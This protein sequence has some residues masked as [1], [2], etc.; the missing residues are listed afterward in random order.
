MEPR[1][2]CGGSVY[3]RGQSAKRWHFSSKASRPPKLGN[4]TLQSVSSSRS[5]KWRRFSSSGDFGAQNQPHAAYMVSR[6]I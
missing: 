6:W 2:S 5:R 4:L 3:G 1:P